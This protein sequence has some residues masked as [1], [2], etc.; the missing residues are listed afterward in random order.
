MK[1]NYHT[2]DAQSILIN[3]KCIILLSCDLSTPDI[4]EDNNS[5]DFENP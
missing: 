1:K 5:I 4:N 3:T 2:P